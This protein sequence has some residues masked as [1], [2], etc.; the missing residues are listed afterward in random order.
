[1]NKYNGILYINKN[2]VQKEIKNYSEFG[3]YKGN[4]K[5]KIIVSL[6]S[7]PERM[8]DVHFA[9]F[10]LLKQSFKPDKIILWLGKEEFPNKE[11]DVPKEILKLKKL[12][13]TIL[14]TKNIKSY[15]KLIPSLK[16]FPNDIIVTADDDIYYPKKWLKFLYQSYLK[17]PNNVHCHRA[18]Q[19]KIDEHG[20][21]LPYSQ[22]NKETAFFKNNSSTLN[23][24]TGAGG[25]LYPPKILYKDVLNEHL[26]NK[27]CPT[28]DDIWFWAMTILNNKKIKIVKNNISKLT[29]INP[30]RELGL[31]GE[32]TLMIENIIKKQNDIQLTNILNQYIYIKN[33]FKSSDVKSPKIDIILPT[34]NRANKIKIAID[35]IINQTYPNWILHIVNDGGEDISSIIEGYKDKRIKY[36]SR[37]HTGKPGAVNYVL[38]NSKNPYIAYMDDDD[39]VFPN[40]LELLLTAAIENNKEFVYSDT[41]LTEIK[42]KTGEQLSQKIENNL[43]VNYE[44]LRF[45]NYINHKQILHTRKLYKKVGEYDERLSILIDWDYI[46]RLAK[47][48]EPYHVKIITG[49]HFLYIKDKQINSISGL[50]TKNPEKVGESLNI[51]FSKD[52]LAMIDLFTKY[53]SYKQLEESNKQLEESN[54]SI[55]LIQKENLE[56][57]EL[58]DSLKKIRSAK[59]FK[60]WRMYNKLTKKQ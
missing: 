38:K 29:Y 56:I 43:D 30:E 36:Y 55:R 13:L 46:K 41:Y 9:I 26:F 16:K 27:L 21:P 40:H 28:T 1:M 33:I 50:W 10:S 12:G 20:F 19:I 17:N 51:I 60:L 31:N 34:Y 44:M 8:Y 18:H 47:E 48:S 2:K 22:W 7:F 59:F 35:S 39:I 49:N 37:K 45:Q 5:T 32:K 53:Q 42:E 3:L 54:K 6:T 4:R 52:K 57:K 11:K 25:I 58:E 23:F 14:W 15:K 24:A